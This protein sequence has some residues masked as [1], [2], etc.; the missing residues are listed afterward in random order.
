[1]KTEESNIFEVR[2]MENEYRSHKEK[3]H[4]KS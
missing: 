4:I 3:L 2:N 1:M